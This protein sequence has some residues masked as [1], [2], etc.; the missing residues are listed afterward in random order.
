MKVGIILQLFFIVMCI[1]RCD[2]SPV[3]SLDVDSYH[4]VID[5]HSDVVVKHFANVVI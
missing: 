5:S 1:G 3:I 2:D 4:S